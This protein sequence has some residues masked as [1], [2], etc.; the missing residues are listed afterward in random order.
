MKIRKAIIVEANR[1]EIIEEDMPALGSKD[2]LVKTEAVGMCHTDLPAFLGTHAME[3]APKGYMRT[4]AAAR[5]P[6]ET[7]HE[8]IGQVVETGVEV[9][10]YHVGEWVSGMGGGKG[11]GAFRDYLILDDDSRM[12]VHLPENMP[13]AVKYCCA[14]PLECI[15]NIVQEAS[16]R[17]GENI[18][19]VGCGFMGLMT[20]AGL[21]KSS[22][23]KIAAFDVL[24]RKLALAKKYGATDTI[25]PTRSEADDAAFDL[26]EGRFFDVVVEITGSM[27]GLETAGRIVRPT[28]RFG[29]PVFDG[30]FRGRGRII[31]ASVYSGQ[32]VFPVSLAYN[33]VT[34]APDLAAVMPDY[35]YSPR[36][37]MA[38]GVK[39]FADRRLPMDELVTHEFRFEDIQKAFETML[40]PD[41]DYIK[42]IIVFNA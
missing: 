5:Y 42:G 21:R 10:N 34:K 16:C 27:K 31:L 9:K 36:E 23:H 3:F 29:L 8:P 24:D 20:L 11:E 13:A 14:E 37:N 4:G 25:N 41:P 35:V 6:S 17:Y 19:V 26:T 39:S 18:A 40:H 38:E 1:F 2:V 33:L 28:H 22:A 12:F 32:E 30:S 15:V 7:G